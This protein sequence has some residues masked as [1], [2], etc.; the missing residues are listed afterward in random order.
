LP[1]FASIAIT[2]LLGVETNITPLLTIGA[3]SWTRVSPVEKPHTGRRR[4]TFCVVIW[5]SGL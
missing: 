4:A 1:V 5:S 2:W 3:D